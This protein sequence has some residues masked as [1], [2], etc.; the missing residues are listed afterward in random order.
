MAVSGAGIDKHVFLCC[1]FASVCGGSQEADLESSACQV[2]MKSRQRSIRF[3]ITKFPEP[4]V[5][6]WN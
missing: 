2:L 1:V 6:R 5:N 4:V 3:T